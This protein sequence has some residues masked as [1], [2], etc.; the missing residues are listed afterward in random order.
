MPMQPL[1]GWKSL[2]RRK[3]AHSSDQAHSSGPS[4]VT[5]LAAFLE[6]AGLSDA[7]LAAIEFEVGL[8]D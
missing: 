6:R 7:Q 8:P 5:P 2:D 1:S 4:R 3:Q